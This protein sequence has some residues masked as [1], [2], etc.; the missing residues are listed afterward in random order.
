MTCRER[1]GR[2]ESQVQM[3]G[4]EE[5]ERIEKRYSGYIVGSKAMGTKREAGLL[6]SEMENTG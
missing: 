3:R 4:S 6:Y 2:R 5:G 1:T